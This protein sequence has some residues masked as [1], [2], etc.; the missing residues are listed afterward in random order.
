MIIF[1]AGRSEFELFIDYWEYGSQHMQDEEIKAPRP[2][3]GLKSM[4]NSISRGVSF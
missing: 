2:S 3:R 4:D 1:K